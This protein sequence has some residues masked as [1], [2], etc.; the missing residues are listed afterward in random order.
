MAVAATVT[1]PVA[2]EPFAGA[3]IVTV[4]GVEPGLVCERTV[5]LL[6]LIVS[7]VSV[8][9]FMGLLSVSKCCGSTTPCRM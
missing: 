7:R 5:T 2:V 4:G 9:L 3:V 1:V 8:T 6:P